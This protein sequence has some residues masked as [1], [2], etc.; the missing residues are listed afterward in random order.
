MISPRQ[1]EEREIRKDRILTG[2][3]EVFQH[4]GL[5]GATMDEIARRAGFGKATLYYYFP[6]KEEVF[7]AIMEKGWQPLW[8]GIEDIIHVD[9]SPKE[10]FIQILNHTVSKIYCEKNLYR[11]LFAAPKAITQMP[12]NQQTWKSYQNRLYGTLK[13]L[14]EEGMAQG[15][16]PQ[17]SPDLLLKAIGGLF[18][19]LLF[20]GQGK[21]KTSEKEV[22]E[23]IA[24][25]L[26]LTDTS[27][28]K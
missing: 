16:F 28:T 12:E 11:F 25:F 14:L 24:S 20:L 17:I 8:E 27:N 2:A 21:E 18:H 19:G 7:S 22:E 10:T 6:S 9:S 4:K 26:V 15:E 23:L 3:L 13:G 1:L 5:E